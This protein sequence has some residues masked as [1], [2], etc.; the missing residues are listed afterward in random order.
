MYTRFKH[1]T[2]HVTLTWVQVENKCQDLIPYSKF[3]VYKQHLFNYFVY[4]NQVSGQ[5]KR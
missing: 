3:F 2:V 5:I 1:L 4:K